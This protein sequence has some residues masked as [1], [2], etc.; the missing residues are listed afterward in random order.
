MEMGTQTQPTARRYHKP[1]TLY[2]I[3]TVNIDRMTTEGPYT[4][5]FQI[6][7]NNSIM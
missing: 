4:A 7:G 3:I 1:F 2:T 5:A 6:E